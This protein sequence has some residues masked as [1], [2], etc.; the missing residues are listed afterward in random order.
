[1]CWVVGMNIGRNDSMVLPGDVTDL[2]GWVWKEGKGN[3][4]MDRLMEARELT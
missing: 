4:D 2:G 3:K 1:M